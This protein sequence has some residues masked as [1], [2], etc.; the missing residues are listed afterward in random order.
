M[1][2]AVLVHVLEGAQHLKDIVLQ[3]VFRQVVNS[4]FDSLVEVHFH[5]LEHD[6]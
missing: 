6:R 3:L 2:N 1:E 5:E 4:P